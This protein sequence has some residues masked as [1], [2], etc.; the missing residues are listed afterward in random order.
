[1][2]GMDRFNVNTSL[3]RNWEH[4]NSKFVGTG[5]PDITRHEFAAHHHRD[6]NCMLVG[7][8][9]MLLYASTAEGVSSA[10]M[11][12]TLLE[13]MASPVGPP[14]SQAP[15]ALL[16]KR[17]LKIVSAKSAGSAMEER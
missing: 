17:V 13:K 14:P 9:D 7:L 6:T 10:R 4:V 8:N 15:A 12:Y 16:T 2:R 3:S 5:N 1:M 11:R